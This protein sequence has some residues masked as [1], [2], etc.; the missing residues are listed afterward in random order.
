[1]SN[2]SYNDEMHPGYSTT[3]NSGNH[4]HQQPQHR[5]DAM[6]VQVHH[7]L[8]HHHS[9]HDLADAALMMAL[10]VGGGSAPPAG[11]TAKLKRMCRFP[12]CTKV[13]KSQ[14]HCQR[15][16]ARAKR[17][18]VEG[19]DK[20][21]QGTHDGMCKRH[22]KAQNFPEEPAQEPEMLEPVGESAYDFLLP[23]S[24]AYRPVLN[25]E[26]TGPR[27]LMPLVEVLRDGAET[28]EAGW[29]RNA[30]RA[31]RG[32]PP[33][34]VEILLLSGGTP[35]ANFRHLAHAWGRERG[36]HHVLINTVCTRRGEVERKRRSDARE[37][38]A[39][40]SNKRPRSDNS[41]DEDHDN[42]KPTESI[43]LHAAGMMGGGGEDDEDDED[44]SS[45]RKRPARV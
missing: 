28:K 11:T 42:N 12:G 35:Q 10:P 36:F 18:R 25:A 22:W 13:I 15:H 21:A 39:G 3:S 37:D 32:L 17:C 9:P 5:N 14:G 6:Q 31:A 44:P 19:C 7:H 16:G 43:Y 38:A 34:L 45:H 26:R 1:M 20:Q 33:A 30:E 23:R 41:S 40:G 27:S 2:N 4:L 29:H 8:Q 24:I